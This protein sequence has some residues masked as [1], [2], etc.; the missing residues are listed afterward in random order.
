M[1][2]LLLAQLAVGADP[3][4]STA[5]LRDLVT[6]AVIENHAPPPALAGYRAHVESELSLIL[7]DTLGRERAGQIEQLASTVDWKRGAEYD[8][9][10]VGYRTQGLGSPVST[11]SFVRGW[12][13]PTLYGERLRL[14]VDV[15]GGR[16]GPARSTGDTTVAVHPFASDRE[17]Y[18]TYTGGDTVTVLRAGGRAIHVVR[19]RVTPHLADSTS[20]AAFDGEIDLDAERSQIVRMRGRFMVLSRRGPNMPLVARLA[21]LTGVAYVEFVNTEVG[22]RYWLP[23]S[24]RTE[25]QSSI[26]VLGHTRAIM[27]IVSSF[28]G[29][30]VTED[31]ASVARDGRVVRRTTWASSDTISRFG[32]WRASVGDATSSVTANDFDDLA[33]DAWKNTGGVRIDLVPNNIDNVL[34]FDRVEGLFTGYQ[35]TVQ[36]R[37]VVPGLSFGA[38][39][40]WAWSEQ[41][42]RGGAHVA[43]QRGDWI[44]GARVERTLAT[45]NDFIRP[46]DPQTGG[47]AAVFGSVDDFDYVDRRLALVSATHIIGSVDNALVTAQIGAGDDRAEQSRLDHGWLGG[48]AFRPNRGVQNGGYAL[49]MIDAEWHPGISGDFVQPGVG[50]RVHHEIGRGTLEW[51]RTELSV[52]ALHYWGSVAVLLQGDGGI[53]TGS[54]IPPQTLF[55]MGGNGALPGYSYKEFVGDRAALFRGSGSYALPIWKAPHRF[56]NSFFIPGVS[57][58]LA[59]GVQG[60]WTELS[61]DAARVAVN[62]LG[63]GALTSRPTD[64]VRATLGLGMTFFSGTIHAGFARPVDRAAP[65]KFTIGGGPVF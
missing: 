49:G 46:F 16:A 37:S 59:V 63:A 35:A 13:E 2:V 27:R 47:L 64:G 19:I 3:V 12:T 44:T 8:M 1:I 24:Q 31:A 45:T 10:V 65:W 25:F 38:Q 60:G 32:D 9:H 29:Y 48:G 22:G 14:G 39:G 40:G 15:A 11:L 42:A 20:L 62:G 56:R 52:S 51:Q 54:T 55:E 53:V 23:A 26:A 18:Y 57:P 58:A 61:S 4:Y 17:R 21:G 43:L 50:A 7:R 28:S 36:M 30:D 33:P 34:R 41:T 6:K 5:A